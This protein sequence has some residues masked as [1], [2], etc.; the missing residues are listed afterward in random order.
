VLK[1][2]PASKL[3]KRDR[4]VHFLNK[5]VGQGNWFWGFQLKTG[6][7]SWG[8]G[9]QIYEDAYWCFLKDNLTS[10]KELVKNYGDVYVIDKLDLLSGLNYK[11]QLQ[12]EDHYAD[13]AIRRSLRRLGLWFK[14]DM[15]LKIPGSSFCDNVI[16]F[17]LKHLICGNYVSDLLCHRVAIIAP[18]IESQHELSNKLIQ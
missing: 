10:L 8:Y 9:L 2:V 6:L 11:K 12:S 1:Y 18:D 14:G 4:F 15:L 17:H 13:I 16:P 5:K 7:Y 3:Q